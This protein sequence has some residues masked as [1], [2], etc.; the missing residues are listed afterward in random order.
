[1]HATDKHSSLLSP[2]QV[3]KHCEY[4]PI[5]GMQDTSFF[6]TCEWAQRARLLQ[7]TRLEMHARD[8]RFSLLSPFTSY[9]ENEV[10]LI[11]T[12][13]GYSDT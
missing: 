6:I 10:M 1:M 7:Y 8:K 9:E 2:F 13:F 5:F 4:K 3:T 11:L 12:Q